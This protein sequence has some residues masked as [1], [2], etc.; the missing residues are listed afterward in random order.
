MADLALDLGFGAGLAALAFWGFVAS[1]VFAGVWN[2][3]RKRDA[4]HE[5]VRRLIESGQPINQELMDRLSSLGDGNPK[6]H[7]QDFYV[8]GLWLVPSAVGLALLALF[9]GRIDP[10]A[11]AAILGA[12]ALTGCIGVGAL[13]AASGDLGLVVAPTQKRSAARCR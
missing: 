3:I 4:Q 8:T 7:D 11:E 6:R 2:G 1:T 5:T 9:M 10:N 13:V 12:A